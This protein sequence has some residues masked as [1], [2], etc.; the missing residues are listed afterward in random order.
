MKSS[1]QLVVFLSCPFQETVERI[2]L[3][4]PE[5]SSGGLT[6]Q[7]SHLLYDQGGFVQGEGWGVPWGHSE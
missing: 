3:P 6:E 7:G 5:K 4:C 1:R 2:G